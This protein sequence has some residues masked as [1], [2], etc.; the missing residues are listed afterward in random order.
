MQKDFFNTTGKRIRILR[1]DIGLKQSALV[2]ALRKVDVEI[3]ANYV[4]ALET[5]DRIPS[6]EVLRG[7]ARVLR[8][9]TDYLLML[10]D[11]PLPPGEQHE[12]AIQ[13]GRIVYQVNSAEEW[14]VIQ[15]LI[16]AFQQLGET[17][18]RLLVQLIERLTAVPPRIIGEKP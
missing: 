8:T 7:L 4:S 16:E 11:D 14:M 3:N 2:E 18:Q 10:T 6:G 15:D 12:P 9:T 1:Q 13:E 5:S 17:D